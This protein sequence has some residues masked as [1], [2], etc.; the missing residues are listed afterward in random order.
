MDKEIFICKDLLQ[1]LQNSEELAG[2]QMNWIASILNPNPQIM[3]KYICI[4]IVEVK[5]KWGFLLGSL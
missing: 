1:I 3:I 4:F 5:N 2:F